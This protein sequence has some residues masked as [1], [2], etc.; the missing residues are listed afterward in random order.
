MGGEPD[1]YFIPL[2]RSHYL[3][4]ELGWTEKYPRHNKMKRNYII[5][6]LYSY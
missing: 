2:P 5:S 6:N 1:P 4:R 3:R